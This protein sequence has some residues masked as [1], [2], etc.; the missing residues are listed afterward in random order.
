MNEEGGFKAWVRR[1][2]REGKIIHVV[3]THKDGRRLIDIPLT[4]VVIGGVLA[5][6]ALAIGVVAGVILGAAIST[7]RSDV[8]PSSPD[9]PEPL[10]PDTGIVVDDLSADP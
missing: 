6:W 3:V 7:E 10:A 8:L 1:V 5:P 9:L 2:W 4:I